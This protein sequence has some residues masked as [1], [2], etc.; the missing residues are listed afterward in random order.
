MSLA[1]R[2]NEVNTEVQYDC[3]VRRQAVIFFMREHSSAMR[4]CA[5]RFLLSVAAYRWERIG[6]IALTRT[7]S[8]EKSAVMVGTVIL[9]FT[10]RLGIKSRGN[11]I[12][13]HL[14]QELLKKCSQNVR[15]IVKGYFTGSLCEGIRFERIASTAGV[16]THGDFQLRKP[17]P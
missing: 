11:E 17:S 6:K 10:W 5:K 9:A 4:F 1:M 14:I 2:P 16:Y 13:R 12:W 15:C 3:K 8:P 7:M